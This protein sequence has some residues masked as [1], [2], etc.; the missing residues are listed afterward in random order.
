MIGALIVF[1]LML[2]A[3]SGAM[4]LI[5]A[6]KVAKYTLLA[7][8]LLLIGGCVWLIIKFVEVT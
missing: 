6:D 5:G 2:F 4:C 7:A 8:L 1:C 3:V